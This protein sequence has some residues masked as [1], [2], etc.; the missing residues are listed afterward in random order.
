MRDI[1]LLLTCLVEYISPE[2]SPIYAH[3]TAQQIVPIFSKNPLFGKTCPLSDPWCL[4]RGEDSHNCPSQ[5]PV[6]TPDWFYNYLL[7]DQL[8]TYASSA[9]LPNGRDS[10]SF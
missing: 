3:K 5:V 10:S 6:P 7:G 9:A 1:S 4:N 8:T 2:Q